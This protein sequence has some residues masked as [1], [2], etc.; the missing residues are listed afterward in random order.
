[1]RTYP[2]AKPYVSSDQKTYLPEDLFSSGFSVNVLDFGTFGDD[3]HDD[4]A[5]LQ[6]AI[7]YCTLS[8]GN[9]TAYRLLIP[10]GI[11]KITDRLNIPSSYGFS[12]KGDGREITTI[13]QYT[14]GETILYMSEVGVLYGHRNFVWEG[15]C[16]QYANQQ[17]SLNGSA[18]AIDCTGFNWRITDCSFDRCYRGIYNL[19]DMSGRNWAWGVSYEN[20]LFGSMSG[21]SIIYDDLGGPDNAVP[22]CSIKMCYV[23]GTAVSPPAEP[24]LVLRNWN[25]FTLDCFEVNAWSGPIATFS[26]CYGRVG[27]I[28][29]ENAAGK[30][31]VD[32]AQVGRM[33]YVVNSN[34]DIA[35]VEVSVEIGTANGKLVIFNA[36][37]NRDSSLIRVK[38][39]WLGSNSGT[40]TPNGGS[41]I[42]FSSVLAELGMPLGMAETLE[43]YIHLYDNSSSED[44]DKIDFFPGRNRQVAVGDADLS[45]TA[46]TA[47]VIKFSATLTADRSVLL[48][49]LYANKLVNG[50]Q[51]WCI[52]R[53]A[54]A[55]GAFPLNLKNS[56]GSTIASI[57]PNMQGIIKFRQNRFGWVI[58]SKHEGETF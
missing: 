30:Y 7:N 28:R 26:A 17:T 29:L 12:I 56:A 8:S 3:I 1:M 37:G 11:Y 2:A 50:S 34:L 38:H 15:F 10:R 39:L 4:T 58:T 57:A 13:K 25:S 45:L 41:V 51:E 20:L 49:N 22:N 9:G 46:T 54:A 16:L 36:S 43:P 32:T 31:M 48:P 44:F 33:I 40:M 42:V 14:D 18:K 23:S 27:C 21:A 53:D 19:C 55:P 35:A 47:Q 5:A 6:A 24:S 52:V